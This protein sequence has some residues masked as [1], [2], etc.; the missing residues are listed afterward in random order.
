MKI[1][2]TERELV[3]IQ[4]ALLTVNAA[5]LPK[6][7]GKHPE[8]FKEICNEILNAYEHLTMALAIM[9]RLK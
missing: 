9:E 7:N 2:Q 6:D 3:L 8:T 1:Q 4:N 5:F